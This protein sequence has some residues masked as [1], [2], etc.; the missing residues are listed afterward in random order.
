MT[1]TPV[2]HVKRF[3]CCLT[4]AITCALLAACSTTPSGDGSANSVSRAAKPAGQDR[5]SAIK[6]L[7]KGMTAEA[8]RT[9]LG[10]PD[11]VTVLEA[12]NGPGESWLYR[13]VHRAGSRHI[14]T[15]T[16]S[17][18]R[19][20]PLTGQS[21]TITEPVYSV[22]TV[23]ATTETTLILREGLLVEW[24]QEAVQSRSVN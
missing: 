16:T 18:S 15:G 7:Q 3:I 24:R 5:R 13:S 17:Y 20:N 8:V 22:E 11:R 1:R 23:Y 14:P 6:K 21:E 10:E 12:P 4:F 9:L 19:E 2:P